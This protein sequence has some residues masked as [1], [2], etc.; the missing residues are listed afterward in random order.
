MR[1]LWVATKPPWPPVDGGRLAAARTL[2]ALAAGGHEITLVAPASRRAAAAADAT[3]RAWV[4]PRWVICRR[5]PLVFDLVRRALGRRPLTIVRHARR[6]VAAEVDRQLAGEPFAIVHAEQVQAMAQ[7]GA[8]ARHGVPV[9][10]RAQN[11]E[12]ELWTALAVFRGPLA[13]RLLRLEARRLAACEGAA[14][15]RAAATVAL[16]TPDAE[17]LTALAGGAIVHAV[18]VPFPASFPAGPSLPGRPA[19]VLFGSRGWAPNRDQER[20]F[21]SA[22]WPAVHAAAPEAIL[23]VFGGESAAG[24]GVEAHPA[25]ADSVDAFPAGGI[26]VVPLRVAAGLR[27]KILEAWSRGLPVVATPQAAA[28]LE[29]TAGRELLL[30]ATPGEFAA[31]I[32]RLRDDPALATDLVAAGRALLVERHDPVEVTV[33]LETVYRR[34]TRPAR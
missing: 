27:M 21:R 32:V 33:Q 6:A 25:P 20:W 4:E 5:R 7:T 11:V 34:A 10:L 29:A 22:A 28:G 1:I 8:A 23:H 15:R 30:A 2:R 13:R 17:R 19:V 9:V 18:P 14:V 26:L 16:T 24:P 3:G 12:S 31:A